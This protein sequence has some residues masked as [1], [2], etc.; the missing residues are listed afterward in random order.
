MGGHAEVAP[1]P[2]RLVRLAAQPRPPQPPVPGEAA[3]LASLRPENFDLDGETATVVL[4]VRN[5]KSRKGRTQPPRPGRRATPLHLLPAR[6]P[7]RLGRRLGEARRRD[8][9]GRSGG[10]GHPLRRRGSGGT[11]LR[12][13]PRAASTTWPGLRRSCQSSCRARR[14]AVKPNPPNCEPR[15]LTGP[16]AVA[17]RL[18]TRLSVRDIPW[19]LPAS[20]AAEMKEGVAVTQPPSLSSVGPCCHPGASGDSER[21]LPDLNRGVTDLQSVALAAW[22]RGRG[23]TPP[24]SAGPSPR[25]EPSPGPAPARSAPP[26]SDFRR[27]RADCSCQATERMFS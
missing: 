19:P 26:M 1:A 18:H 27:Q 7:A 4:A 14:V 20:W 23:A 17:Q 22:R 16:P 12:R 25:L 9:P 11:A 15:E 5:D 21:P 8:A 2:A 6:R 10:G 24:L 3:A 13:L